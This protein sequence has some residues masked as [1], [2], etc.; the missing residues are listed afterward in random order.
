MCWNWFQAG[1]QSRE[2]GEPSL[3]A[4]MTRQVMAEYAVD[5]GRVYVAGL[6]AG[7]AM[8]GLMAGAYPHL[9][10]AAG[11]HFRLGPRSAPEPPAA[12]QAHQKR[13]RGGGAPPGHAHPPGRLLPR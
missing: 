10:A 2:R 3:I 1:D 8:A 4:G 11:V 7:G 12:L 6:S 13:G 9:Y 5:A